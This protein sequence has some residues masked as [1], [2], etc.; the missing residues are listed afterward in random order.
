MHDESLVA[1]QL[2]SLRVVTCAAP[3]Y[4]ASMG[5]PATLQDLDQ[6]MF[7]NFFSPKTGRVFPFDFERGGT[8]QQVSRP[9]WV[10]ANDADTYIAAG[11][12]GMGLMQTPCNRSVRAH[13]SA[14]VRAFADWVTALC[15]RELGEAAT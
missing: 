9:H 5:T 14:K 1:R 12:A 7:V 15:A 3:A 11:V 2:G 4:L 13:L 6:H 8:V 10:S